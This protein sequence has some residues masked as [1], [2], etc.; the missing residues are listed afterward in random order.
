M[1]RG[2]GN[3]ARGI[4]E[5]S[6]DRQTGTSECIAYAWDLESGYYDERQFQVRH[7]RDWSAKRGVRFIDGFAPF[8]KDPAE[9]ALHK[10]YIKG[11]VHFTEAGNRLIYETAR[12]E[13][14]GDW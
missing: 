7:W 9:T 6:R 13:V 12:Q 8:F 11:D 5:I 1:A 3:I 14:G 2:W 4:K 10:N